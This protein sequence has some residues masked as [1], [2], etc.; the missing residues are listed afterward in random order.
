MKK[1]PKGKRTNEMVKVV[2]RKRITYTMQDD[3]LSTSIRDYEIRELSRGP[4]PTDCQVSIEVGSGLS[5]PDVVKALRMVL[6]MIEMEGLP[7]A[8]LKMDKRAANRFVSLAKSSKLLSKLPD[9]VR[10]NAKMMLQSD[11]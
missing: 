2:A 3:R 5:K 6:E 4:E 7:N 11:L 1:M 8:V 10:E 9:E